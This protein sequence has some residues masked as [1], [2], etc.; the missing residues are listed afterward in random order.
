MYASEDGDTGAQECPFEFYRTWV[1]DPETAREQVE[2]ITR[3]TA[4]AQTCPVQGVPHLT[5]PSVNAS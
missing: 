1:T 3:S 2:A 4:G 5:S